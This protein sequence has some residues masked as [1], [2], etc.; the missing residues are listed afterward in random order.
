MVNRLMAEKGV[1]AALDGLRAF[2]DSADLAIRDHVR[3]LIV[4]AGKL[5]SQTERRILGRRVD[6]YCTL[7]GEADEVNLA[8]L[9]GLSDIFLY[10]SVRGINSMAAHE[11]LDQG[12]AVVASIVPEVIARYLDQGRR[13]PISPHDPQ[14]IRDALL[15]LVNDGALRRAPGRATMWPP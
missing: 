10:T 11:A 12:C 5:G 7:L 3:C 8:R 9:L 1:D 4:G 6:P 2:L 15:C 14:A 13:N